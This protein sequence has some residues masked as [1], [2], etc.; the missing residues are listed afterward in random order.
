MPQ[1]H[2]LE[3]SYGSLLKGFFKSAKLPKTAGVEPR[4][5]S[6][7]IS[8]RQGLQQIVD[9]LGRELERELRLHS[10]VTQL[11]AGP[12]GWTVGAAYQAPEIFDAVVYAAPAYS[13]A[14]IDL[15]FP[16]G[17]RLATLSSIVHPP[18]VVVALGYGREQVAHPLDGFGFLAPEVER[19]RVMGVIFSSSVFPG[20]APEGHVLLTA[21]AA[22]TRDPDFAETD[23]QTIAARVQDELRMLL[24]TRGDPRYRAIQVWPRAIP[25]YVLGY[26]R[27]KE[28]AD[29]VEQ[30]NAGLFLAGTY[31]DGVAL[32]DAM[33]SGERTASRVAK[34]VN[35]EPAV[36]GVPAAG[37][38]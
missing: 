15:D 18:V 32:S 29:Q 27:F 26:G 28:I 35:A 17:E 13:L 24:G 10:P 21:F 11:R 5:M 37:L 9:A 20:R 23:I 6:G 25:Q 12:K 16:G 8:F 22:G 2:S 4:A 34:L 7:L 36:G 1:L 31:R 14:D 3:R 19:R 30:A 33:A 38:K